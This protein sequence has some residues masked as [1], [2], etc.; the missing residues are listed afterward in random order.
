MR[1]LSLFQKGLIASLL[2]LVV[3]FLFAHYT[4]QRISKLIR[5]S[6][7]TLYIFYHENCRHCQAAMSLLE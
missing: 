2:M 3:Y 4:E 7:N 5:E 6:D 1:N